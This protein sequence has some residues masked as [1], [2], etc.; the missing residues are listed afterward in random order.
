[1]HLLSRVHAVL[2]LKSAPELFYELTG[3]A[4]GMALKE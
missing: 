2:F 3:I 1:M 4:L